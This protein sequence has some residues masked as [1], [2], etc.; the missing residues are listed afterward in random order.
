MLSNSEHCI[1]R[2]SWEPGGQSWGQERDREGSHVLEGGVRARA[3]CSEQGW[4]GG[5][6]LKARGQEEAV[7]GQV[8]LVGG[9]GQG[10][11]VGLEGRV[12][13]RWSR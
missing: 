2:K 8:R 4:V 11:A 9:M 13:Q 1:S 6:K 10:Q 7:G 5:G 3:R 12:L